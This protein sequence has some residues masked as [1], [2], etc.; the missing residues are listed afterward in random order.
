M[1]NQKQED[2]ESR[3]PHKTDADRNAKIPTQLAFHLEWPSHNTSSVLAIADTS[4]SECW[5]KLDV[6]QLGATHSVQVHTG[7][8]HYQLEETNGFGLSSAVLLRDGSSNFQL[9]LRNCF[10]GI[11]TQAQCQSA[12][13]IQSGV[14]LVSP[15]PLD[16]TEW[17]TILLKHQDDIELKQELEISLRKMALAPE[18]LTS[19][20]S[21]RWPLVVPQK[22]GH[23]YSGV[24]NERD[25]ALMVFNPSHMDGMESGKSQKHNFI[26]CFASIVCFLSLC[27]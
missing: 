18:A 24:G 26:F 8:R 19:N 7:S 9:F 1:E 16:A 25:K 21:A 2:R 23:R 22:H 20:A 13:S 5:C 6:F 14:T 10:I 3:T 12:N 15:P 4:E 17:P 11:G 27:G